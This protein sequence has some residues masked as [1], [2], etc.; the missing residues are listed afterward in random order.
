LTDKLFV[1]EGNT[2]TIPA[3]TKIYSTIDDLGTPAKSDDRFGSIVVTRGS[4][5]EADGEASAP[6][7]QLPNLRQLAE[8]TLMVT[9]KLLLTQLALTV[10]SGEDLFFSA[11]PRSTTTALQEL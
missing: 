5:I 7:P 1:T 3:G 2:L 10:V 6:I 8:M 11:T 4:K 9:E